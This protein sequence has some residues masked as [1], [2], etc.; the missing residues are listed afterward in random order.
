[1]LTK[2]AVGGMA[3]VAL[4]LGTVSGCALSARQRSEI[5]AWE[6]EAADLGHPEVKCTPTLDSGTA[7]GLSFL[8][9]GI[10]G[11]YVHRPGLGVTGILFWPLSITWT[12]PI[13]AVSAKDYDYQQFRSQILR[14]R[15][16]ARDAAPRTGS[17]TSQRGEEFSADL[18]RIESLHAAGKISDQEYTELRR[19]LLE[20]FGSGTP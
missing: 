4:L 8:P 13:A 7:L 6:A 18:E 1:M 11:F 20:R 3:V 16:E 9:F 2:R 10:A 19:L 5:A 14:L 15:A 17:S 12:A